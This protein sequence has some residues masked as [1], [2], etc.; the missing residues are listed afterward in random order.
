VRYVAC[1]VLF[2]EGALSSSSESARTILRFVR[3]VCTAREVE[4]SEKVAQD[5]EVI[6]ERSH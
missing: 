6:L 5:F 2:P 1:V 3:R 4:L